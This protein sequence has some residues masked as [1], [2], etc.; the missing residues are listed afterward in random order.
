MTPAVPKDKTFDQLVDVLKKHFEPKP[1]VIT[2][3]INFHKRSQLAGESVK[4]FAAELR[5][6]MIHCDFAGH[7]DETL[8]DRFLCGLKNET[9]Q[10][11]LLTERELKL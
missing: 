4:E 10:K 3:R 9:I 8:R 6:L 7:L 2:E 5:R 1:L 11:R